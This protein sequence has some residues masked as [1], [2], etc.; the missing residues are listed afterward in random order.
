MNTFSY[1]SNFVIVSTGCVGLTGYALTERTN[2]TSSSYRFVLITVIMTYTY[3]H[4]SF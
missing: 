1:F 3:G 2:N 4:S